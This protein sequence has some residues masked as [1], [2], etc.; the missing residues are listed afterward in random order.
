LDEVV[1]LFREKPDQ[2]RLST[3]WI[4]VKLFLDVLR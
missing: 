1:D 3:L 2:I 4:Q